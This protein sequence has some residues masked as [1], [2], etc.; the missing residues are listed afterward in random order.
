ME[1]GVEFNLFVW[2]SDLLTGLALFLLLRDLALQLN[3]LLNL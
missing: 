3:P 2:V 1:L